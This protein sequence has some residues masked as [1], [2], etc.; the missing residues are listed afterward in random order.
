[1]NGSDVETNE[2]QTQF[3]LLTLHLLSQLGHRLG[4]AGCGGAI[5]AEAQ[6]LLEGRP[7]LLPLAERA[8]C[9]TG[10]VMQSSQIARFQS[11]GIREGFPEL[12]LRLVAPPGS[13]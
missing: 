1:M 7:R 5:G 8:P 3:W 2:D 6:R 10:K 9:L 12:R 4:C 13:R 11:C